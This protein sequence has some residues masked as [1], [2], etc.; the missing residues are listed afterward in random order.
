ML[1]NANLTIDRAPVPVPELEEEVDE[2]QEED[3]EDNGNIHTQKRKSL[4]IL[5]IQGDEDQMEE[6]GQWEDEDEE[7]DEDFDPENPDDDDGFVD[8][9]IPE[10][11][12]KELLAKE[13]LT[14]EDLKEM[15]ADEEMDW[16]STDN[17]LLGNLPAYLFMSP[18]ERRKH[19]NKLN[20]KYYKDLESEK[21]VKDISH[22]RKVV[23][24]ATK[25]KVL[26]KSFVPSQCCSQLMI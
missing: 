16:G 26:G 7:D 3:Q 20:N 1:I 19:F 4:I 2:D 18:A 24:N 14:L 15:Q 9:D 21:N 11:E 6:E 8:I 25:N 5:T 17:G 13:G 12:L 10:E 23:F 22:R